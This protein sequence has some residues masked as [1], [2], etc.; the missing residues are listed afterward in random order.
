[1]LQLLPLAVP[2]AVVRLTKDPIDSP[3]NH[4]CIFELLKTPITGIARTQYVV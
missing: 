4:S 1:M 3:T 2:P